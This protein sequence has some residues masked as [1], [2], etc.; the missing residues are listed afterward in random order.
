MKSF[1]RYQYRRIPTEEGLA[2][3]GD[4]IF[5]DVTVR[6]KDGYLNDFVDEE[7]HVLPAIE[8]H[9]GSHIE[10]WHIGVLHCLG[11]PAIIDKTDNYEEWYE[12]G[13]PVPKGGRNG[14]TDEPGGL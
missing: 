11:G 5:P 7:G 8:T 10:H 9:D 12:E 6:L 14:K 13:N 4:Y 1:K 3:S 2:A